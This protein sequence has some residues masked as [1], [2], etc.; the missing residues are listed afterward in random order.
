MNIAGWFVVAGSLVFFIGATIGV[1]GV[2]MTADA[3]ERLALLRRRM[4]YWRLGQ[5]LYSLGPLIVAAGV[6]TFGLSQTGGAAALSIAGGLVMLAGVAGWSY[7]CY[8]RGVHPAEFAY[9]KLPGWP[10]KV[11]VLAT[12]AG[13]ALMG[14]SL[15]AADFSPWFYGAVFGADVFFLGFYSATRD[16]PPFFFYLLLLGAGI[17]L[18]FN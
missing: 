1:P 15:A 11:Y 3:E 13:L 12:I 9:G 5:P 14:S 18:A 6:F 2:F 17:V 7:D 10:F 16:I 8:L 4:I